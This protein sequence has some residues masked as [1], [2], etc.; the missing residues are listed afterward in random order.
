MPLTCLKCHKKIDRYDDY[1]VCKRA[2][3]HLFHLQCLEMSMEEYVQLRS[4]GVLAD[5]CCGECKQCDASLQSVEPVGMEIIGEER[6]IKNFLESRAFRN[7]ISVAIEEVKIASNEAISALK[8]EIV[9]LKSENEKLA[10]TLT[11]LDLIIRSDALAPTRKT[12]ETNMLNNA[13]KTQTVLQKT[14]TPKNETYKDVAE[15]SVKRQNEPLLVNTTKS[16]EREDEK[17]TTV[18]HRRRKHRSEASIRGSGEISDDHSFASAKRM[19]WLYVGRAAKSVTKND[20]ESFL[21][22]RFANRSFLVDELPAREPATSRAFKVGADFDLLDQLNDSN[23][24][25]TGII[26]KRFHFFR[27]QS[28]F[29][30]IS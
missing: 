20:L 24:W 15:R 26:I 25:P 19:A 7:L 30:K 4:S 11:N 29:K 16:N 6:I 10:S 21:G 2:G 17:F 12:E 18:Q 27:G 22:S 5:W 14:K 28:Q 9:A 23:L 8:Q 3:D 1:L 13:K